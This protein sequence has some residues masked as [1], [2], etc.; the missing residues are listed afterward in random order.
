MSIKVIIIESE[1]GWG[2]RIDEIKEF[3]DRKEAEAFC[4]SLNKQNDKPYVPD[5]YIYAKI[6]GE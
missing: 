5:W 6:E 3:D 4:E 1:R 2:Q